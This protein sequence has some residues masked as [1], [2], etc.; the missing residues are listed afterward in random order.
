MTVGTN[1]LD[2]MADYKKAMVDPVAK[3]N[4]DNNFDKINWGT[5]KEKY[6]EESNK[7]NLHDAQNA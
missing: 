3:K 4:F 5:P 6:A 1:K 2:P 7:E